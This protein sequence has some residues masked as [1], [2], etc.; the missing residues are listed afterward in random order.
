MWTTIACG[1]SN[2]FG[3]LLPLVLLVPPGSETDESTELCTATIVYL[4]VFRQH[5]RYT[6][7]SLAFFTSVI[8]AAAMQCE[9]ASRAAEQTAHLNAA[10]VPTHRRFECDN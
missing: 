7:P 3:E 6:R 2:C 4:F 10:R 8:L 9:Q 1:S 5:L